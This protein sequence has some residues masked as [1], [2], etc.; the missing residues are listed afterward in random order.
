M[1]RVLLQTLRDMN[2]QPSRRGLAPIDVSLIDRQM[3]PDRFW[4]FGNYVIMPAPLLREYAMFLEDFVEAF[5]AQYN[6]T[7]PF[8]S[9]Q[10][11]RCLSYVT[12]RLIHVWAVTSGVELVYAVDDPQVRY[13][14]TCTQQKVSFGNFWS[15]VRVRR[16]RRRGGDARCAA[17]GRPRRT[18]RRALP[19]ISSSSPSGSI[20]ALKHEISR[21]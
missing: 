5:T 15:C 11:D 21:R 18:G 4:P 8:F 7:C 6:G 9:L 16:R 10:P 3:P 14:A 19:R 1:R 13:L 12:E 20:S 2:Q 17:A